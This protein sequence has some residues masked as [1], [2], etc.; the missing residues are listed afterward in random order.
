M[1]ELNKPM[2]TSRAYRYFNTSATTFTV[3][4]TIRI[5]G[6]DIGLVDIVEIVDRVMGRLPVT[7]FTS[8]LLNS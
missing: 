7:V 5:K 1:N 4:N 8:F 2:T 6:L 3:F